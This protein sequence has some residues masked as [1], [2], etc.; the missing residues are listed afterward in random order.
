MVVPAPFRASPSTK[1]HGGSHG[2]GWQICTPRRTSPQRPHVTD[3]RTGKEVTMGSHNTVFYG[4]VVGMGR[5]L[6][7]RKERKRVAA[8]RSI[9]A[10]KNARHQ[11]RSSDV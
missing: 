1:D 7:D 2:Q 9:K 3:V 6:L 4:A 11:A 5:K 8:A 10:A